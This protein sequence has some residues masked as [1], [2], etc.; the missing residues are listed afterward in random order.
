[1]LNL[2]F[3]EKNDI[4]YLKIGNTGNSY[5]DEESN[6]IVILHDFFTEEV[7]GYTIFDFKKR[8]NDNSIW[9]LPLPKDIDFNIIAKSIQKQ[10]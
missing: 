10:S 3:D 5:G 9:A 4:L 1:M 2:N 6:G 7:T 8:Y